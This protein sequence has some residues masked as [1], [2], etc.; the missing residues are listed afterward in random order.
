MSGAA[1]LCG[2]G[3]VRS[4]AGLVTV[5][6]PKSA[7][8]IVALGNPCYMASPLEESEGMLSCQ[9]V[10]GLLQKLAKMDVVAV[11]P[12]CGKGPALESLLEGLLS[13]PGKLVLDADAL[14]QLAQMGNWW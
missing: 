7:H 12:G 13:Q 1:V 4:G 14:N 5:F 6:T 9:C 11:G 2:T 3:A 8:F 10:P